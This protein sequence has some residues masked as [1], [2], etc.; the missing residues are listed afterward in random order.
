MNQYVV[1][2]PEQTSG[3]DEVS[4]VWAEHLALLV[5]ATALRAVRPVIV[6]T[7]DKDDMDAGNPV[8]QT[9]M[10]TFPGACPCSTYLMA[11]GISSNG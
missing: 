6:L 5:A 3:F 4:V 7:S 2:R 8:A 9:T 1:D 10:T 11:S